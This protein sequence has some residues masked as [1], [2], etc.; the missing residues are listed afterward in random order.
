MVTNISKVIELAP[1]KVRR[2]A[3][4]EVQVY[5]DAIATIEAIPNWPMVPTALRFIEELAAGVERTDSGWFEYIRKR[6]AELRN[7]DSPMQ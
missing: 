1:V 7:S 3:E 6:A 2:E 5:R 4:A